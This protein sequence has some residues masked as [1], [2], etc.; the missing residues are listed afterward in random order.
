MA[1]D[2]R[3]PVI[4]VSAV[5]HADP[6]RVYS[7]I[8]DYREGHPRILPPQFR[9]LV[10][11]KGGVGQGTVVRF[12]MHLLGST[13]TMR[14]TVSEPE[15]GRV[16]AETYEDSQRT[17]TSFTVEPVAEKSKVTIATAMDL[18]RGPLGAIQRGIIARLLRPIYVKELQLLEAV[19]SDRRTAGPVS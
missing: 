15:P 4:S 13:R 3:S 18:P 7:T 10:V 5:L 6:K 16:L 17:V 9:G 11:E 8:A 19:A 12:E 14:G 1:S 2:S